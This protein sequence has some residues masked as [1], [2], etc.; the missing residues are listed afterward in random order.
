MVVELI[1]G[2]ELAKSKTGKTKGI[3]DRLLNYP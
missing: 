3:D 1:S 2:I